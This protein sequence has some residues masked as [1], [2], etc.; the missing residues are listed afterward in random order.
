MGNSALD[1]AV[2]QQMRMATAGLAASDAVITMGRALRGA[3]LRDDEVGALRG[4]ADGF[5]QEAERLRDRRPRARTE[6]GG[7]VRSA[8]ALAGATLIADPTHIHSLEEHDSLH[9][10]SAKQLLEL[11]GETLNAAAEGDRAQTV[12]TIL[13]DLSSAIQARLTTSGESSSFPD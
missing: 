1:D 2:D 11:L 10:D 6:A 12:K 4:L 8:H 13:R 5:I 7:Y 9:N 3:Q